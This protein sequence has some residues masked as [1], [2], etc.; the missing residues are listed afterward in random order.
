MSS[1][2]QPVTMLLSLALAL[3]GVTCASAPSGNM[4]I[5]SAYLIANDRPG[6]EVKYDT[7]FGSKD[8]E[9]FE[10]YAGP[11]NTRYGEVFWKALPQV[12]LPDE[13]VRRF[14]NGTMAVIGY[15]QDQVVRRDGGL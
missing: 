10:I 1:S 5:G 2:F 13:I 12:E 8:A 14:D 7:D 11:I 15:E 4:N 9:Y 3:C 6:S